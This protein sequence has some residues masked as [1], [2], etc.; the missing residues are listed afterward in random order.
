MPQTIN[1]KTCRTPMETSGSFWLPVEPMNCER[2]DEK[3]GRW[4]VEG[5]GDTFA[6]VDQ[7]DEEVAT[8]PY[9]GNGDPLASAEGKRAVLLA[10]APQLLAALEGLVLELSAPRPCPD[11]LRDVFLPEARR[12][13]A[14]AKGEA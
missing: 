6:I 13:I 12:A 9:T 2:C 11:V 8:V 7:E 5:R 14:H 4:T 10:A 3:P 1:C